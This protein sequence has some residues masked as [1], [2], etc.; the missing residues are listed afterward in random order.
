[1]VMS[2]PFDGIAF[3]AKQIDVVQAPPAL[4]PERRTDQKAPAAL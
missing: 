4:L 2:V 1:M 3:K